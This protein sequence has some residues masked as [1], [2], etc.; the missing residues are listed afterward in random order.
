MHVALGVAQLRFSIPLGPAYIAAA[1]QRAGHRVS[2][3]HFG[4]ASERAIE[5]LLADPPDLIGYSLL[6]GEQSAYLAFHRRLRRRLA[7]PAMWGGPHAT[8]FPEMLSEEG[9]DAFCLGEG[10]EA[11]V[12]FVERYAADG[13]LPLDV[14]NFHVRRPD[15]TVASNPV[16]PLNCNLDDLPFPNR[17]LFIA[18][19]PLLKNHGIK[20]FVAHRGCPH[21]C[22]YCFN[23][24]YHRLYDESPPSYRSRSPE[25]ICA[26]INEVRAASRLEMVAF[27]DDVFTLS[28][29][30]LTRFAEIYPREVGLPYS[31]NFRLDNCTREIA[32]LLAASGCHLA[33][34]GIEAGDEAIRKL[35]GR[36]MSDETIRTAL[37]LLHERDI[38]TITENM[39]GAPG[40]SF[41]Q[42]YKTLAINMEVRPTL[43][44][45][46]IFTPYPELPL[47][48]YAIKN[49][50]FHGDFDALGTNY[51][52]KSVLTFASEEEKTKISNLRPFF[53]L[54]ARHRRFWPLVKPLL[55]LPPNA[56]FRQFGDL[57]DG[58]YLKKCLPYRDSPLQF[59]R[60]LFYYLRAYR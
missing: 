22:T 14:A 33:Y 5:R 28:E 21:K 24:S 51:Y 25:Q 29:D 8:F 35:F 36:K 26:E 53:S 45:C 56:L 59:L 57:V 54:L 58:Y 4:P 49:G 60:T 47:T 23:Q 11:A 40:E 37:R 42:A 13:S 32:D 12:E 43:A 31:C 48:R 44:N 15:G 39:I 16:R 6:S 46:S 18:A 7:I 34:V 17:D 3:V 9:L 38:R 30:W 2:I 20:H 52:H 41:A 10:E 1:L 50:Y 27:V 19:H 55:R